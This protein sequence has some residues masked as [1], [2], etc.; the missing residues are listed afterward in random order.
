[1][2]GN[3]AKHQAAMLLFH[4]IERR[5]HVIADMTVVE[6][7]FS[8]LQNFCPTVCYAVLDASIEAKQKGR[9]ICFTMSGDQAWKGSN[10]PQ[11][12]EG[13]AK[14]TVAAQQIEES[15]PKFHSIRPFIAQP[16]LFRYLFCSYFRNGNSRKLELCKIFFKILLG[17]V[18]TQNLIFF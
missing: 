8:L 12:Y 10:G 15:A 11:H 2:S 5:E 13:F 14:N 17:S 1:M 7:K 16:C 4:L 6:W 18:L 3:S 9:H